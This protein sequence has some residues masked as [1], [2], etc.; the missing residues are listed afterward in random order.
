MGLLH[1]FTGLFFIV[2]GFLVRAFPDLIAGYNTMPPERKKHIDMDGLSRFIRNGLIIMG[3]A[4]MVGYLLFNWAGWT[5]MANMVLIIVVFVGAAVLMLASARFD[6]Y[7]GKKS[8]SQYIIFGIIVIIITS[9]LFMGFMTSRTQFSDDTI[10][11]TGMFATKMK[12][13]DIEKVELTDTIPAIRFKNNGF[14]LRT[15]HNGIF[16]LKEF[17][18]CRLY[19]NSSKGQYLI[20][21]EKTGFRTILRYKDNNESQAIYERIEEML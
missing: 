7:P 13:S 14:S 6:H 17:G 18:R 5:F 20:I 9:V 10:R 12:I 2:L 3:L 4:M 15:V 19:I 16:T 8:K 11:F 21:T 1:L